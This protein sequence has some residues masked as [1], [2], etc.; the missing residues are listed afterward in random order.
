[1]CCRIHAIKLLSHISVQLLSE[2]LK[3]TNILNIVFFKHCNIANN[4]FVDDNRH[5]EVIRRVNKS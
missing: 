5:D 2:C 4:F 1:M 3:K